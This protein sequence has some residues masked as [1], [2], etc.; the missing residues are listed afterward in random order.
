M[1][2]NFA[3]AALAAAVMMS[4]GST[5]SVGDATAL[6]GEWNIMEVNGSKVDKADVEEAPFLGFDAKDNNVYGCTGC[7]RLTGTLKV[8]GNGGIDF[9]GFGSLRQGFAKLE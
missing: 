8:K 2:K 7:N 9:A 6:N 4:C 5:K 3:L 1:K